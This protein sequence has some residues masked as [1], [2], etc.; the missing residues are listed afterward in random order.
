MLE[1]EPVKEYDDHG[2]LIRVAIKYRNEV[3]GI[4]ESELY[5]ELFNARCHDTGES[6]TMEVARAFREEILKRNSEKADII[7]L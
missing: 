1:K 4:F 3:F 2:N 7:N 5:A 6:T